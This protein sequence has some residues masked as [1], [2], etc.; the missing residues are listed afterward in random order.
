MG[1]ISRSS[2]G[3]GSYSK[4]QRFTA[5]SALYIT[6]TTEIEISYTD[7][8]SIYNSEPTPKS[9]TKTT[10]KILGASINQSLSP[11]TW[12]LQPYVKVGAAQLNRR[13]QVTYDGS[14]LPETILKQ[15]SGLLGAGVRLHLTSFMAIRVELTAYMPD[16]KTSSAKENYEWD[17]GLS[18]QF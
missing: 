18:F 1:S 13:Q 7:A 15:P 4:S 16:F 17:A 10:D 6:S 5:T 3:N 9:T 12:F 14:E 8:R 11:R 2:F